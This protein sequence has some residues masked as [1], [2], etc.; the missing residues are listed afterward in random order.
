MS[1]AKPFRR[2][3]LGRRML[4]HLLM[5][6]RQTGTQR[7]VLETT[8]TWA[9]VIAFYESYGFRTVEHRDDDVHMTITT[10]DVVPKQE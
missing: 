2:Q 5:I 10:Q 4:D 9:E 3:G 8:E 6:A 7:V 1:V